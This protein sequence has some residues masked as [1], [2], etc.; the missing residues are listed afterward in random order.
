MNFEINKQYTIIGIGKMLAMTWKDEI[1]VVAL[2]ND[3]PIDPIFVQK[4]K[5]KK[6]VLGSDSWRTETLVFE[7]W[8]LALKIDSDQEH[9]DGCKTMIGNACFNF[10][11]KVEFVKE[12][13][14]TKNIND[15]FNEKD[16]VLAHGERV[17]DKSGDIVFPEVPTTHA[18]ILEK[19]KKQGV[20][21][22]APEVVSSYSREEAVE[23]GILMKNPAQEKFSET[24]IITCNLCETIGKKFGELFLIRLSELMQYAKKKYENKEFEGDNDKDFFIIGWE[25]LKIWFVRNENGM[26]T[27]MLPEDY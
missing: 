20:L 17:T 9:I 18:I 14:E 7:G 26:L 11:G 3:N 10:M 8:D 2:R 21:E 16:H 5:R 25:Q 24:D 13:I 12:F 19:R 4:G 22:Q 23:D 15:Y 1:K 27:A 6:K